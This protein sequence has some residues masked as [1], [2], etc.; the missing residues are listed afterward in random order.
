VRSY[1]Q[2]CA[3][4]RALDVVGD[5]WVLL[6]VREL[7]ALGPSRYSDLKRGLPGIASNLLAERLKAMEADGLVER[8]AAPPPIGAQVYRLTARGRALEDVLRALTRWG[9]PTMT[10][11]PAATDALQT[12]WSALLAGLTLPERVP[13]GASV[14]VGIR[15]GDESVRVTLSGSGFEIE[16]G[17]DGDVDVTL[18]GSAHVIGGLLSGL[19][20]ITE[21]TDLGLEVDGRANLL[22]D[23]VPPLSAPTGAH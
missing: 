16:R 3:V 5:R 12:Q 1:Q 2:Y 7:L 20:T 4:A 14:S 17:L 8:R 22:T 10:S 15:T 21:A 9:L 13:A 11:G 6:I 18:S 19:L 23:L